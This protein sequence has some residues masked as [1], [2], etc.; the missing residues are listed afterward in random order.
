MTEEWYPVVTVSARGEEVDDPG[1]GWGP[2]VELSEEDLAYVDDAY[3]RF[4]KSQEILNDAYR[5]RN[6]RRI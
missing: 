1:L 4:E 5:N 3:T 2:I 6:R